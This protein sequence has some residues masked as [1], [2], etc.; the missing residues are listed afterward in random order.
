[1]NGRCM[2]RQLEGMLGV[3]NPSSR[4]RRRPSRTGSSVR[5]GGNGCPRWVSPR[6]HQTASRDHPMWRGQPGPGRP[7]AAS[8]PA[9]PGPLG[10]RA[11]RH[12]PAWL[13]RATSARA[14]FA[15][16]A[17]ETHVDVR[18]DWPRERPTGAGASGAAGPAHGLA[19]A[20][21]P[22]G[23]TSHAAGP[24]R[25]RARRVGTRRLPSSSPTA[26]CAPSRPVNRVHAAAGSD[27]RPTRPEGQG[28]CG[29]RPRP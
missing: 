29:R 18:E 12:R 16:F 8:L 6:Q 20:R 28:A 4:R 5:A 1:M 9:S 7:G 11:A 10:P 15:R 2:W 21:G 27:G 26:P 25:F 3:Q 19:S 13:P 17:S 23:P 22:R 14:G 24:V